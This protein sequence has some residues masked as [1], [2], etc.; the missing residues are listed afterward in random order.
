MRARTEYRHAAGESAIGEAGYV[1][2]GIGDVRGLQSV[3]RNWLGG[4]GGDVVVAGAED[5]DLAAR[6][7][8]QIL[9][10]QCERVAPG[11]RHRGSVGSVGCE[12]PRWHRNLL[13]IC[14]DDGRDIAH[15]T[16]SWPARPPA[17]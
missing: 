16:W 6:V 15:V 11:L 3:V 2:P 5:H 12:L 8:N 14:R 4:D 17:P 9:Q 13:G 10:Q 7:G 1:E